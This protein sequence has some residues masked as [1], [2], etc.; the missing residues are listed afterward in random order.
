MIY[1][2]SERP[3]YAIFNNPQ[4]LDAGSGS[5]INDKSERV[6]RGLFPGAPTVSMAQVHKY[7]YNSLWAEG[8]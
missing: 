7:Q 8:C 3:Y 4:P 6:P 5:P 1:S 2:V